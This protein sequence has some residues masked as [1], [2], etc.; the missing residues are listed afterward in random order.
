[1]LGTVIKVVLL[2]LWLPLMV[3]AVSAIRFGLGSVE[4]VPRDQLVGLFGVAWPAAIPLTLALV[5]LARSST[6][7]AWVM[8]LI[9]VALTVPAVIAAGLLGTS[10]ILGTGIVLSLPAWIALLVVRL[11]KGGGKGKSAAKKPAASASARP[12]RA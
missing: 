11:K 9:L 6:S 5:L 3:L 2:S 10:G 12:S 8:G 1:M 4:D 7:V